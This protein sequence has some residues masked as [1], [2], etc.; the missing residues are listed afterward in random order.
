MD[1]VKIGSAL[2]LVAMM[3]FIFPRMRAAA[4]D[5]PKG[6]SSEWMGFLLIVLAVGAFVFLLIK[7]V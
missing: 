6:S 5:A 7:M 2:F 4:K 1:W 3:V